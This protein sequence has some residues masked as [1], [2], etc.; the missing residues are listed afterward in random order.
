MK[1]K[2]LKKKNKIRGIRRLFSRGKKNK[3]ISE[4]NKTRYDKLKS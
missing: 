1:L 3:K 4:D 2:L